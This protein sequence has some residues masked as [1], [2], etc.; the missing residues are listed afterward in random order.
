MTVKSLLSGGE[1]IHEFERTF[2]KPEPTDRSILDLHYKKTE[3][4]LYEYALLPRS[5]HFKKI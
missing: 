5:V 2:T 1:I 3:G 4:V